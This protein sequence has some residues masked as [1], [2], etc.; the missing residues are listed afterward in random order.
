MKRSSNKVGAVARE[1]VK[2]LGT[3]CLDL[4]LDINTHA[5]L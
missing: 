5:L 1:P 4:C 3:H 2:P